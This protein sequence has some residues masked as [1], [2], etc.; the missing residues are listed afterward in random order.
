MPGKITLGRGA[1]FRSRTKADL[2]LRFLDL[3]NRFGIQGLA[4]VRQYKFHPV[5]KWRFDFAWP[6]DRLAVEVHGGT[7]SQGGHSRGSGQE[8][9]FEKSNA[10]VVLGWRLLLFGI[11]GLEYDDVGA[12]SIQTIVKCVS[13]F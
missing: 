11:K 5:R 10:A 7:F 8:K 3:W 13:P 4:P 9:D 12:A 1:R 6:D 2:E